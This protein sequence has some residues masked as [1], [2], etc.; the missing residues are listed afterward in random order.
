[1]WEKG[2]EG[3]RKLEL[4]LRRDGQCWQRYNVPMHTFFP[5]RIACAKYK[6]FRAQVMGMVRGPVG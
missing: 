3:G 2:T 4:E 6:E 5:E 1:M